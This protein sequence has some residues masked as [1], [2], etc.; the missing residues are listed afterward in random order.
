M[1]SLLVICCLALS[2][3]GGGNTPPTDKGLSI[4]SGKA[5]C[6]DYP[7]HEFCNLEE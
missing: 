1:K 6:E 5:F 3:C 4:P 7:D 2:A